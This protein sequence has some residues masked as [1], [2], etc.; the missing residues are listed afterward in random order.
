MSPGR[1]VY[2]LCAVCVLQLCSEAA[3][4]RTLQQ[5][6]NSGELR[7]AIALASPWSMRD[8]DDEFLGYE[9]DIAQALAADLGTEARFIVYETDEL[10]TAVEIGE[11]D[12]VIAALPITAERALHVNFSAPH[13]SGGLTLATRLE[14]TSRVESLADLDDPA[15]SLAV[16]AATGAAALAQRVL[17]QINVREYITPAEAADALIEGDVDAYLEEEPVPNFL[18][19]EHAGR[20]DVPIARPLLERRAGFAIAKGD[21]DFL[22]FLN[23]W[24][25]AREDDAWLPATFRYWFRTLGWR[26]R[27][28]NGL[29]F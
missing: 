3:A 17:P 10:M 14:S 25:V 12:I 20:I 29:D 1:S 22:S 18:A 15:Y 26:E 2:V 8:R 6:R 23:A 11:A 19:L 21:I 28:G 16:V 5:V 13:T 9:I 27:L 24:I 4:A 7:V